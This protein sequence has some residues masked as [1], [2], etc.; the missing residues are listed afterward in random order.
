MSYGLRIWNANGQVIIDY[1]TK[2]ALVV[3]HGVVS[4]GSMDFSTKTISIPGLLSTDKIIIQDNDERWLVG[5]TVSRSGQNVSLQ[6]T[7]SYQGLPS[8]HVIYALRT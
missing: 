8:T 1:D 7:S 3:G 2:L 4:F 6:R 5:Y